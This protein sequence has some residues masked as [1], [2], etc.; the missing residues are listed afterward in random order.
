MTHLEWMDS[1]HRKTQKLTLMQIQ[2][3]RGLVLCCPLVVA[4]RIALMVTTEVRGKS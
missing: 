2:L 3:E 4:P 1:L